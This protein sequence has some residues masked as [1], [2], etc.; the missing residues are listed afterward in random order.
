MSS[1]KK[2][3]NRGKNR[4]EWQGSPPCFGQLLNSP[5]NRVLGSFHS[6]T[7]EMSHFPSKMIFILYVLQ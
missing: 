3:T 6:T 7:T 1:V 4:N 2:V 5:R